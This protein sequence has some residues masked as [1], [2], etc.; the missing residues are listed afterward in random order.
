MPHNRGKEARLRR[1][2]FL[3]VLLGGLVVLPAPPAIAC[4][5][6]GVDSLPDAVEMADGAFVGSLIRREEPIP[7][8]GVLDSAQVVTWTFHVDQVIKGAIGP[9][10]KVESAWSG[11]SC[12]LEV[13]VGERVGLLLSRVGEQWQSGLCAQVDPLDLRWLEGTFPGPQAADPTKKVAGNEPSQDPTG[14]WLGALVAA[15]VTLLAGVSLFVHRLR[16]NRSG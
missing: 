15:I 16:S 6:A 3:L 11:V 7:V 14:S 13:R 4:S 5:C 8:G 12:G 2:L 10:V 1:L 9:R